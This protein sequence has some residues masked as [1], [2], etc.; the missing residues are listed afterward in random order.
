[1]S[2]CCPIP[3]LYLCLEGHFGGVRGEVEAGIVAVDFNHASRVIVSA[4]LDPEDSP[5]GYS[6]VW[7]ED[8]D[9]VEC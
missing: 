4:V 6:Q 2:F 8:Q 5:A 3:T 9:V 1:M 7:G